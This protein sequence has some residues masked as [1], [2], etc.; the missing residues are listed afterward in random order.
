MDPKQR[1]IKFI[2]GPLINF[3][4][5]RLKI[6][7]LFVAFIFVALVSIPIFKTKS[8]NDMGIL[9]KIIIVLALLVDLIFGIIDTLKIRGIIQ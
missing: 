2:F 5:T 7:G 1:F 4:Q 6:S 9:R 8:K 3:F